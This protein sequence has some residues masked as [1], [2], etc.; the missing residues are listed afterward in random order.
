MPTVRVGF[1]TPLISLT[2]G[3]EWEMRG[4]WSS[5]AYNSITGYPN[6]RGQKGCLDGGNYK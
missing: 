2:N 3:S 1:A 5:S 4:N 6:R